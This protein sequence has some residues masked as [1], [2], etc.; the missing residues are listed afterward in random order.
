MTYLAQLIV[1]MLPAYFTGR[2]HT[3]RPARGEEAFVQVTLTNELDPVTGKS[4]PHKAW[5]CECGYKGK[6]FHGPR[7]RAHWS[8]YKKQ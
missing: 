1:S 4:T 3:G 8:I 5:Q 6:H 7:V 2:G